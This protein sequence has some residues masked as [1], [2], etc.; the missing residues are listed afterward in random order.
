MLMVS[1]ERVRL[2]RV[3]GEFCQDLQCSGVVLHSDMFKYVL[4]DGI[5][6]CPLFDPR[7]GLGRPVSSKLNID[8]NVDVY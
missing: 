2:K 8:V 7:T 3:F 6:R 4:K 1:A 5:Q